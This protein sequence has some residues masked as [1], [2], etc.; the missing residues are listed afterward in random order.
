MIE[1]VKCAS[2]PRNNWSLFLQA[3]PGETHSA[4]AFYGYLNQQDIPELASHIKE[5]ISGPI[6]TQDS[7]LKI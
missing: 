3:A 2:K 7:S 1:F 4:R 5:T 6:I